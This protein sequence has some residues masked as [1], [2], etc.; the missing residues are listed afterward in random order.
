MFDI[1]ALDPNRLNELA[2]TANPFPVLSQM[3]MS[4]NPQQQFGTQD[5]MSGAGGMG[6]AIFGSVDAQQMFPATMPTTPGKQPAAALS[7]QQALALQRMMQ[8]PDSRVPHAPAGI[9]RGPSQVKTSPVFEQGA[10][11]KAPQS[12][13]QIL[14]R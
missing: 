9:G 5:V 7:V 4:V 12:L 6:N 3:T 14:G 2:M 11:V 8:A 1:Q 10:A 13:A